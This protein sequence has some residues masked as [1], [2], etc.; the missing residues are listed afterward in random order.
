MKE[1][2]VLKQLTSS[3]GSSV[4]CLMKRHLFPAERTSGLILQAEGAAVVGPFLIGS[5]NPAVQGLL[6]NNK[7][8]C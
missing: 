3:R 4:F 2:L 8:H 6:V 1:P 5:S 7:H